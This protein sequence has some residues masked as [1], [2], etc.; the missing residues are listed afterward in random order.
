MRDRSETREYQKYEETYRS[1]ERQ[2]SEEYH[3]AQE[4]FRSSEFFRSEEYAEEAPVRAAPRRETLQRNRRRKNLL[5]SGL[6]TSAGAV[7]GTAVIAVAV[8]LMAA[9][10]VVATDVDVTSYSLW[11]ELSVENTDNVPLIGCLNGPGAEEYY[12]LPAG[13]DRCFVYFDFLLPDEE[14]L[15]EV[16]GDGGK[17]YYSQTYR[18]LAYEQKLFPVEGGASGDA[19]V[20]QFAAEDLPEYSL[21]VQL[22]GQPLDVK[23]SRGSPM[24]MAEGLFPNTEYAVTVSDPANGEWLYSETMRTGNAI[25]YEEEYVNANEASLLFYPE[26]L[27]D[28]DLEVYLD[29]VLQAQSIDLATGRLFLSGLQR[30]TAYE[31]A[32]R[33]PETGHCL[34]EGEL[35]TSDILVAFTEVEA[36]QESLSIRH[37]LLSE[38]PQE[39]VLCLLKDGRLID[40]QT[41]ATTQSPVS[42]SDASGTSALS[43]CEPFTEYTAVVMRASDFRKLYIAQ[44]RTASYLNIPSQGE[45][46]TA[47][48]EI[49]TLVSRTQDAETLAGNTEA[50][51]YT[52]PEGAST[53][54]VS[55]E[56]VSV[57][58]YSL[59]SLVG[60][61]GENNTVVLLTQ[62]AA[63]GEIYELNLYSATA[64]SSRA[65]GAEPIETRLIA[66][67]GEPQVSYPTFEVS[68]EREETGT[69]AVVTIKHTGGELLAKESGEALYRLR[70]DAY[71]MEYVELDDFALNPSQTVTI[72][73]SA[74]QDSGVLYL[75]FF[76][77]GWGYVIDTVPVT[78][79]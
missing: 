6:F 5:A 59:P 61:S 32:V 78:V 67:T 37:D 14:Y 24:F 51:S 36:S 7:V 29:G 79:G 1:E 9:V 45:T 33:D 8:V 11:A 73:L 26:T 3:R 49:V 70:F 16:K 72:S 42:A 75:C 47:E 60:Y 77:Q 68:F 21:N 10:S 43:G 64:R 34:Y 22:D 40:E 69:S 18:T 55:F 12:E 53:E 2:R 57:N 46:R 35:V 66:V 19:I 4:A 74:L 71:G 13:K 30:D 54:E 48:G 56:C 31:L 28:R 50:I 27:P 44:V 63:S 65:D 52:L 25:Y 20:L 58:G 41:A 38:E 23:L 62:Y 17:V 15:F 76:S 39:V